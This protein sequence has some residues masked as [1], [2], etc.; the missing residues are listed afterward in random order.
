ML[1]DDGIQD[2]D[3]DISRSK[4]LHADHDPVSFYHHE[5]DASRLAKRNQR[6]HIL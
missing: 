4:Q 2:G 3:H 6:A 1:T 5:L